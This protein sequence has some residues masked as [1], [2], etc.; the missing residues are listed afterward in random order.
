MLAE[1]QVISTA[2]GGKAVDS[3]HCLAYRLSAGVQWLDD[4]LDHTA[5][6]PK[7]QCQFQAVLAIS[8]IQ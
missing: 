6:A 8:G 1:Q 7:C 5:A 2:A 3:S 4:Q